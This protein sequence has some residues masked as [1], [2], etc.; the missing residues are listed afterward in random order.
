MHV[1]EE[2]FVHE[3]H[4]DGEQLLPFQQNELNK[5]LL[6]QQNLRHQ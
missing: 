1:V 6:Q 2:F 3:V 4:H 5:R